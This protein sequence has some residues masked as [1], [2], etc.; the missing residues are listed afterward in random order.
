MTEDMLQ[1]YQF[2]GKFQIHGAALDPC[3]LTDVVTN[4][5]DDIVAAPTP[6]S[7]IMVRNIW[8]KQ[9]GLAVYSRY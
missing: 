5:E 8:R 6:K 3:R 1:S 4:A 9:D 7:L 2:I